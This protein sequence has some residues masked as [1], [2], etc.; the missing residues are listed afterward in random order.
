MSDFTP[1]QLLVD[2]GFAAGLLL[3]GQLVRSKVVIAQ[4]LFLPAGVIGGFFGL[5][6]GPNGA[7]VVPMSAAIS[8]Y[9]GL[10]I[11]LVFATLPFSS[12]QVAFASL[13]RRVADLWTFSCVAI[14]LQWGVGI[15][16]TLGVLR[17]VWTEI[18]PGFGA[19]IA[20]GFVGGHGTAA[21]MGESFRALGWPEAGSLA[22]TAATVGI[23]S[24]I[25]GGM[26]WIE[27]GARS[28]H[29]QF[30]TR[31]EDLPR[32]LRTG[33]VPPGERQSL[34][35][36]TVS[37]NSM[38]SLA[39]HLGLIG[40]AALGGY[41]LSQWSSGLTEYGKLPV[42]C[43]AYVAAIVLHRLLRVTQVEHYVDGKTMTHL[44]G[45]LT[46]LLVVFGI[47]SIK[48]SILIE[49]AVP[50]SLISVVGIATCGLLFRLLGPRLFAAYWFEHSLFTWGW[51][52]GVTA[53]AIALLRIVDPRNES[54][55]LADFGLAYLFIAPLE[56]G[57]VVI[58]PVLLVGGHGWLVAA[59]V[60]AGAAVLTTV[61]LSMG[62]TLK[63]N[64]V[65]E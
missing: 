42:F 19:L 4:R 13:S 54:S 61:R 2:F 63:T 52:T 31:F 33:L 29:A 14:L 1:W 53:M 48:L 35:S 16:L 43:M 36:G 24:A 44:G 50:L 6:L 38:D 57:L 60:L 11:A 46:D 51:I 18:N 10:L 49:F 22:M 12:A 5:A 62:S 20:A 21:A 55:S 65:T 59:L 34:G 3:C 41:F 27:W 32:S 25:I 39:L 56:I 17:A 7:G 9:P 30:V 8:I 26:I 58:V 47:A 28:G 37:G 45:A 40:V 23:L 64:E 15:L